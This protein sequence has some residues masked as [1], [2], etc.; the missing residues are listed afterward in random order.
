M[1]SVTIPFPGPSALSAKRAVPASL[2]GTVLESLSGWRPVSNAVGGADITIESWLRKLHCA[3]DLD[4]GHFALIV[5]FD[6][7]GV[8][9][10][11]QDRATPALPASGAYSSQS[12]LGAITDPRALELGKRPEDV[13]RQLPGGRGGIH[14]FVQRS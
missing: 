2:S 6:S 3:A 9:V 11:V 7:E 14:G 13:K 10:D 8:L 12:G 1:S 4:Y 5:E